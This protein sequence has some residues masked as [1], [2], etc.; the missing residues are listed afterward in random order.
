[1]GIFIAYLGLRQ[2]QWMFRLGAHVT[3]GAL[4]FIDTETPVIALTIDDGPHAETTEAILTVLKRHGVKAT[5]FMVSDEIPGH[6]TT[7]ENLVADGYELGHHMTTDEASIRLSSDEFQTK[8]TIADKTLSAYG[9][10]SWFRPGMGWYNNRMLNI[11][12]DRGYQLVLGS[13]YPYDTHLSSVQFAEW[14]VLNNLDPG[15]ILVLH[16]GPKHRGK[17]TAQLLDQLLPKIQQ[18]GY[19]IVTLTELKLYDR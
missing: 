13:L 17:R 11:I 4:F 18:R 12:E 6:E 2:P 8:F 19:Q 14:F 16:D 7:L 1:G 5:F 3:P 10:V 15:D 9:P